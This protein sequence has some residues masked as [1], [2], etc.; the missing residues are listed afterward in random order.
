LIWGER[1]VELWLPASSI[2]PAQEAFSLSLSVS[3][4][5]ACANESDCLPAERARGDRV[6]VEWQRQLFSPTGAQLQGPR[7]FPDVAMGLAAWFQLKC[8]TFVG[9]GF[10]WRL[11]DK[12]NALLVVV[13]VGY[14]GS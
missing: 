13:S 14:L 4:T 5:L 7:F 10:T 1:S 6:Y 3:R 12:A 2:A 9:A 11:V 8:G